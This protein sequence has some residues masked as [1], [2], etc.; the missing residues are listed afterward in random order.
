MK[1]CDQRCIVR[2]S[3]A[4]ELVI[5]NDHLEIPGSDAVLEPPEINWCYYAK[6]LRNMI[7]MYI[8]LLL[9]LFEGEYKA[10]YKEIQR[11]VR[12]ASGFVP[13]T[14]WIAHVLGLLGV[15]LRL[16]ANRIDPAMRKHPCPPAKMGAIM[17]AICRLERVQSVQSC[18]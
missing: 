1:S 9:S 12:I 17:A 5:V 10:T 4:E 3:L 18:A 7:V 14:C 6:D 15:R 16:A 11:E 2:I 13:K 8:M